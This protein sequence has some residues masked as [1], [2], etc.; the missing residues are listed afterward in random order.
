MISLMDFVI[1]EERLEQGKALL[2]EHGRT[3]LKIIAINRMYKESF[4]CLEDNRIIR[5]YSIWTD[6]IRSEG[7]PV[8]DLGSNFI[9]V[10]KLYE[11]YESVELTN[12]KRQY[13]TCARYELDNYLKDGWFPK[14]S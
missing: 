11:R 9:I 12:K 3:D 4:V 8:R 2:E 13:T 10:D 1:A 7:Y 14:D 5:Y 6:K